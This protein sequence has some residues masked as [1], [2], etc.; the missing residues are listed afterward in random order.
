MKA[1]IDKC[2]KHICMREV[3]RQGLV[4]S[5]KNKNIDKLKYTLNY[6]K[7][8]CLHTKQNNEKNNIK[9]V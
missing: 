8:Y 3:Q 1:I 4:F 6:K 5:E 9:Q 2:R 7:Q